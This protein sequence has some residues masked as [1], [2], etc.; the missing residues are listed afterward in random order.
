MKYQNMLR[1]FYYKRKNGAT[2]EECNI[3][4]LS[5]DFARFL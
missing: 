5:L 4:K 2:K 3:K 1:N